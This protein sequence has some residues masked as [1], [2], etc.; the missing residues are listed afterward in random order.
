MATLYRIAV[1]KGNNGAG[2]IAAPLDV[3][4]NPVFS[5]GQTVNSIFNITLLENYP[6]WSDNPGHGNGFW[7]TITESGG[8]YQFDTR[9]LSGS[10]LIAAVFA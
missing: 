6:L 9:D 7:F 4:S 1:F 5:F 8:I 3:N 2:L 10:T